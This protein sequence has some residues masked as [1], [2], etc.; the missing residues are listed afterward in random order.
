MKVPIRSLRER[1]DDLLAVSLGDVAVDVAPSAARRN[2]A[3]QMR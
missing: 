2:C 3:P 1:R